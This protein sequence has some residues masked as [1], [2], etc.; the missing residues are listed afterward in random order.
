MSLKP[1]QQWLDEYGESHQNPTNKAVHWVC[2]PLI[3]L[4]LIGMLWSLPVPPA[5]REI[6]PVLNWGVLFMMAAVVYYFILSPPLA[7][8]M[9]GVMAAFTGALYWLDGLQTPLWGVCLGIFVLAWIGQFIGHMVEG[10]RPSFF[11]DM[12][13]LMI[14]PMWLLS[15]IYQRFG[16]RY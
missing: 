2:V 13:F 3:A 10:K 16:I 15:F 7:V 8:G 14:G 5:F 9:I 12:Q 4:S 6:S 11:Q 1:V